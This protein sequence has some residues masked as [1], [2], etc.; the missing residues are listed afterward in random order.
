L[1]VEKLNTFEILK[2]LRKGKDYGVQLAEIYNTIA[3]N[4][5]MP[6]APPLVLDVIKKI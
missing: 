4:T 3:Q 6:S 5:G 1:G 2:K